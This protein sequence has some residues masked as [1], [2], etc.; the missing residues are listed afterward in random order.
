MKQDSPLDFLMN[1]KVLY[2]EDEEGIRRNVTEILELFFAE[3]IAVSNGEEAL[4]AYMICKP[5]VLIIDIFIPKMDG[6][7]FVSTIRKE[8]KKIP[9]VLLSA[10][11]EQEYLWRA[12]ELKISKYLTKP[13]TKD[14]LLK[15]LELCAMEL[16]D[17]T[18]EIKVAEGYYYPFRKIFT[19]NSEEKQLSKAESRLMDYLISRAGQT[20]SYDDIAEH[21][22]GYDAPP[23]KDAI[24][25][26]VKELRKKVGKTIIK[27]VYGIG[28]TLEI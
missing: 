28:Y 13:F 5:D 9:I 10:H 12:V 19:V 26:L 16:T 11:T 24:K 23:G 6:L 8:D 18:A 2:A 25:A 14:T 17:Y 3:V 22:W 27:N 15:A 20:V 7:E 4:D 1:K 21:L